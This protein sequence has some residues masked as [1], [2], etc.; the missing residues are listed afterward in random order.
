M[1]TWGHEHWVPLVAQGRGWPRTYFPE[2]KPSL[3]FSSSAPSF[4]VYFL[5]FIL[6]KHS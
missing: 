6:L 2:V 3:A 4:S 1:K 5:N